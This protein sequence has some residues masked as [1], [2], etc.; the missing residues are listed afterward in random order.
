MLACWVRQN[1]RRGLPHGRRDGMGS[2][3]CLSLSSPSASRMMPYS[4]AFACPLP[5]ASCPLFPRPLPS[6]PFASNLQPTS[7]EPK[8]SLPYALCSTLYAVFASHLRR[9]VRLSALCRF[10]LTPDLCQPDFRPEPPDNSLANSFTGG[11]S[12]EELKKTAGYRSRALSR[13][14]RH[15]T[16]GGLACTVFATRSR[17]LLSGSLETRESKP[18]GPIVHE[19]R[20]LAQL[21][22]AKKIFVKVRLPPADFEGL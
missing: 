1:R 8:G 20:T 21:V 11:V 5:A 12:F 15:S 22:W 16:E 17:A 9:A 4:I 13:S 3:L 18:G 2:E 14:L 7:N 10:R 6:S 19:R